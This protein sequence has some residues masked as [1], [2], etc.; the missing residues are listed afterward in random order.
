MPRPNPNEVYSAPVDFSATPEEQ[1]TFTK[2]D[3]QRADELLAMTPL[4]QQ[5]LAER[6][7]KAGAPTG[8]TA[9]LSR[10]PKT[11]QDEVAEL[12]RRKQ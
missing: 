7:A 4:G 2:T 6:K 5:V 11:W 1:A 12:N 8:A 10:T 3:R 9:T